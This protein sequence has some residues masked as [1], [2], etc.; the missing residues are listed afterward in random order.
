MSIDEAL[1]YAKDKGYELYLLFG[2]DPARRIPS[3]AVLTDVAASKRAGYY[4]TGRGH[5][6]RYA[7]A[8]TKAEA[9][10]LA[11]DDPENLREYKPTPRSK[12][13]LE[14]LDLP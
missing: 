8:K 2:E 4:S 12:A 13:T 10:R 6:A 7:W 5:V 11:V 9:I 3:K 1:A 14:D